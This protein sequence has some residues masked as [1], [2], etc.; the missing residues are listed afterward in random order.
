MQQTQRQH[1]RAPQE[2]SA[3]LCLHLVVSKLPAEAP[4][5]NGKNN[6]KILLKQPTS[7]IDETS[8]I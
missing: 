7:R 2:T 5:L 8:G 6:I 1:P 4:S 3:N